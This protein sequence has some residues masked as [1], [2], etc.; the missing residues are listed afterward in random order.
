[1]GGFR[2]LLFS[3]FCVIL[4]LRLLRTIKAALACAYV[5]TAEGGYPT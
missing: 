5:W 3:E 2:E 1:M 4:A